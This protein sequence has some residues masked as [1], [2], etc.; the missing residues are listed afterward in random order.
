METLEDSMRARHTG[1]RL[2]Y[3]NK[4]P[5]E[6]ILREAPGGSIARVEVI[7]DGG[8]SGNM[9][10]HGDNLETLRVLRESMDGAVTLVYIDPPFATEQVFTSGK[11]RSATVSRSRRDAEAY[12]DLLS[13]ARFVEFL[14][15]RLI[16]VREL[17]SSHGSIYVHIGPVMQHYV[18]VVMD[19]VFGAHR[20]VCDI[21]R[22]KC[23]PK[24]F[25]R[26]G[27]GNIKDS[28][29]FYTKGENYTWNDSREPF[30]E[31]DLERLFKKK[32][33]DGR[34]YTTTPLHAPG[35]TRNGPTGRPWRGLCPPPGRH[36]RCPPEELEALER[37]GL[38]EWS[39]RGNPRKK[40]Y[41][42][43]FVKKGKKRQDIWEFKDEPYPSYPTQKNLQML[44]M[45]IE[46]S[47]NPGDT[48]LDCFCG[49]GTTLV[50]AQQTGRRWVGIDA[51]A[52]AV[53]ETRRRLDA[54][55]CR[56]SYGYHQFVAHSSSG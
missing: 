34:R 10:I 3:S 38:I 43:E 21:G 54:L 20:F 25:D 30:T 55:D 15:Q 52:V 44:R 13:G 7:G 32:G 2:D 26:R 5:E 46:A 31:A 39:S 41:A 12:P 49:S 14:R 22:I 27:Y 24:N 42:D 48:V 33:P 16:L 36:W 1:I 50:A 40:I 35:E 28:L 8:G 51:S 11:I 19:E 47:S 56:A 29:L 17:L 37:G 23:N 45:I 53:N 18:K 6:R 9:L 4:L